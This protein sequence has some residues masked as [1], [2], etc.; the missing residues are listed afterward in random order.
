VSNNTKDKKLYVDELTANI[1]TR[2]SYKIHSSKKY[3]HKVLLPIH[4]LKD[5]VQKDLLHLVSY[6]LEKT[7]HDLIMQGS[8]SSEMQKSGDTVF[9][10]LLEKTYQDFLI[11]QYGCHLTVNSEKLKSFLYVKELLKDIEILFKVPFYALQNPK[12]S[13]FV[14]IYY[15]IYNVASEMFLE[16]L[17]DNLI[18]ELANC[19]VYISLINFSFLDSFRQTLYRSKYLS[20]RNFEKFKNNLIWQLRIKSYIIRPTS[21]YNSC[22]EVFLLKTTGIYSKTIYANRSAFFSSLNNFPLLTIT[23]IELK[24]FVVCRFEDFVLVLG[25]GIRFTLTSGVGQFI[26]FILR[27]IVEGL[28]K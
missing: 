16:I 13:K 19:I 26:G 14:A 22:Y 24:D 18:I 9:L 21:F 28:K 27:G 10:E 25:R 20:L 2:I 23:L 5:G 3:E 15:P 11:K 17:I 4:L 8:P 6:N 7:Y 1:F 12:S